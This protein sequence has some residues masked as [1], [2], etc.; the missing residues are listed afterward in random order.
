MEI[1]GKLFNWYTQ[2]MDASVLDIRSVGIDLLFC[3]FSRQLAV[4]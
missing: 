1:I 4:L 2:A 3:L